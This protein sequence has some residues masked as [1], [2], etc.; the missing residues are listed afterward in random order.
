MLDLSEEKANITIKKELTAVLYQ[1]FPISFLSTLFISSILFWELLGYINAF[2][3]WGWFSSFCLVLFFRLTL[4]LWFHY[5]K[6]RND[7]F[8]LHYYLFLVGACLTAILWG[9]L[10][11]ILMPQDVIH[12]LFILII[13]SGTFAGAVQSLGSDYIV[14]ISYIILALGPIL[15]WELLQVIGGSKLYIG[16]F[17]LMML[18]TLYSM[19]IGHRY[20][21]ILVKNIKLHLK[22]GELLE[23]LVKHTSQV[24]FFNKLEHLLSTCNTKEEACSISVA[25]ISEFISSSSGGIFL[26]TSVNNRLKAIKMW[27]DTVK[28]HQSFSPTS[29]LAMI[30]QHPH[31]SN[32]QEHCAHYRKNSDFYMCIPLKTPEKTYGLLTIVFSSKVEISSYYQDILLRAA[33][34]IIA[35]ITRLEL[36]DTLMS[37]AMQ[38]FLTGLYNKRYLDEHLKIEISRA[39]RK[40]GQLA[41]IMADIDYFK[42]I[43]DEFGHEAGNKILQLI[44]N[45]LKQSMRSYDTACR[46]GGEE[47]VLLMPDTSL[48]VA[49]QRAEIM[50]EGVKSLSVINN[51]RPLSGITLSFG[52]AVFPDHGVSMEAI[53]E[54]ADHALYQAKEQGRDRVCL[55]ST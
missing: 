51:D 22:N 36:R 50:R 10:G 27:G 41:I 13:I 18:F 2:Y 33:N 53:L 31:L 40:K 30:Q 39:K 49:R 52:V 45:F 12:Q 34:D 32:H 43:N 3:L 9:I 48:E 26:F 35:A 7:L 6:S 14:C 16:I 4:C 54:A 8:N 1:N 42:R 19:I 44:S 24:E 17:I 11:S 38:D 37:Q 55:A 23:G 21:S 47:F 46:Y 20:Y 15:G 25:C 28:P 29:C 5:T